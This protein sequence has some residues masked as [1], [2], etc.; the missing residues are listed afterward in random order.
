[1]PQPFLWISFAA[2]LMAL[3]SLGHSQV[4]ILMSWVVKPSWW[5][6]EVKTLL[7]QTCLAQKHL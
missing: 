5:L 3:F 4:I 1:M 6:P 7:S 2:Q